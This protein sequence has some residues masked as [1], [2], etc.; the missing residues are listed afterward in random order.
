MTKARARIG[1]GSWR[2]WGAIA[3][4]LTA[5][6]SARAVYWY[7]W[8]GSQ[9]SREPS[10]VVPPVSQPDDPSHPPEMLIPPVP[11]DK[12][13]PV[14]PPEQTPEPATGVIGLIGLGAIAARRWWKK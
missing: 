6:G 12:P 2:M 9:T 11:V 5:S 10:L 7:D 4:L 3:V 14:G 1:R 13:P 8:P